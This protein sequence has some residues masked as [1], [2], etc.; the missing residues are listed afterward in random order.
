L[1]RE[2][3]EQELDFIDS[4]KIACDLCAEI[5][6]SSLQS[7]AALRGL[8]LDQL[9]SPGF[10]RRVLRRHEVRTLAESLSFWAPALVGAA[11]AGLAFLAVVQSIT[12]P[13]SLPAFRP[14]ASEARRTPTSNL[15]KFPDIEVPAVKTDQR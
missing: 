3:S 15:P 1:E 8:D 10:D 7:L 5:G 4:H 12:K 9:P 14:Q 13:S 2:L 11:I 6:R